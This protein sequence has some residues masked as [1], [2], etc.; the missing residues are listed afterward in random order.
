M[1][2][3]VRRGAA[4]A[5]ALL[6]LPN[7]AE[8]L[9][10]AAGCAVLVVDGDDGAPGFDAGTPHPPCVSVVVSRRP[11]PTSALARWA[12]IVVADEEAASHLAERVVAN[13]QASMALTQ[14][15]RVTAGL[16]V[17]D[18]LTAE[19]WVYGLLQSGPE[20]ARWLGGRRRRPS[21]DTGPAVL[22]DTDQ[23]RTTVVLNRPD[24]RNALNTAMR[25]GLVDALRALAHTGN[26][27]ELRGAGPCFCA[28]GDLG[29]F[30]TT[31]DPV[32]GHVVR[33]TR[34][35]AR[36]LAAVAPR[37]K[38]VV[39][40]A[41]VGAGVELLAFAGRV[42][43]APDTFFQLPEIPMGLVPGSGGTVSL[44]RRIG[45]QRTAWLAV[46][47]ARLDA[48]TALSWG[49]VDAVRPPD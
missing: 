43:A 4:E 44:P 42:E 49:L 39:H 15:L 19:S 23:E 26:E 22:V 33:A 31:P 35:P 11:A 2:G 5:A 29:E 32:S 14:L 34:S 1:S 27:I 37:V 13:P 40:G 28:G 41:C 18:A 48:A 47:G 21:S 24:V 30:G 38:A 45:R 36:A 46:T 17:P 3:V 12:D 8:R 10:V 16:P 7:A 20:F 9:S 6:A 25:D